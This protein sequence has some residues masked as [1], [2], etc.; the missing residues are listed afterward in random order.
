VLA[1]LVGAGG[2][3]S[4]L[5]LAAIVAGAMRLLD[6]VGT[7]AV[8]RSDRFPVVTSAAVVVCLVVASATHLPLLALAA[9]ACVGLELLGELAAEPVEMPEA[10]ASRAG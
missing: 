10:P 8:G 6:A 3:V 5:L 2:L 1:A 7:A 4:V 9:L